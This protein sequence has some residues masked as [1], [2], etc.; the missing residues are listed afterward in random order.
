VTE[1]IELG[2]RLVNPADIA[3]VDIKGTGVDI[4]LDSGKRIEASPDEWE[5]AMRYFQIQAA[6]GTQAKSRAAKQG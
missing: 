4:V 5:A 6:E 2:S 1:L 3:Y